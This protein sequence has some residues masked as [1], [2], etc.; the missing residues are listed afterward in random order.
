MCGRRSLA[1]DGIRAKRLPEAPQQLLDLGTT[2][3]LGGLVSL[4]IAIMQA[5]ATDPCVL[6]DEL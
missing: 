5:V 2:S 6:D 1:R 4:W 3:G